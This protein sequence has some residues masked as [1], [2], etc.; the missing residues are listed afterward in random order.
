MM[1]ID[2][3]KTKEVWIV[4]ASVAVALFAA[5]FV[6]EVAFIGGRLSGRRDAEAKFQRALE[7]GFATMPPSTVP[8]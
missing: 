8:A 4:A 1:L 2:V 5:Y 7:E 6:S 3:L